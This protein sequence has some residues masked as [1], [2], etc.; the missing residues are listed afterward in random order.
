MRTYNNSIVV[1]FDTV[2]SGNSGAGKL[3]TVFNTGT[4]N[5]A[6]L[7]DATA[8]SIDNPVQADEAGNY[9][10]NI[11][12]GVYDIYIDYGLPTQTSLLNELISDASAL[13]LI[14]D[15][16]QAYEFDTMAEAK[17]T[18]VV[19]PIGK[20][21]TIR[22]Y[23]GGNN[24]GGFAIADV[25]LTSAITPNDIDLVQFTNT[26]TSTIK[27]RITGSVNELGAVPNGS[28]SS[29]IFERATELSELISLKQGSYVLNGTFLENDFNSQGEVVLIINGDTKT[30]NPTKRRVI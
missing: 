30:Y 24:N 20:V 5:K 21:I 27:I 14:N 1:Q 13:D 7:F 8:V 2:D 28:D 11:N 18:S 19:F 15:L 10:F 17:N 25:V 22:E 9:K 26:L 6:A 23:N 16:S 12:D 4:T 3:V 29:T